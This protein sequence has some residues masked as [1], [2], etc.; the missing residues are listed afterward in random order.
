MEPRRIFDKEGPVLGKAPRHFSAAGK[1]RR[2]CEFCVKALEK[3]AMTDISAFWINN[4][5]ART[6]RQASIELRA[7]GSRIQNPFFSF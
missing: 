6:G 3:E 1:M 7:L 4:E 5:N 2:M